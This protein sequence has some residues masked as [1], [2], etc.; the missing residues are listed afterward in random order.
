KR[1]EM[2]NA[3]DYFTNLRGNQKTISRYGVFGY[4]IGGPV[5]IPKVWNVAKNKLFFFWSQEYTRT[6]PASTTQEAKVP[7]AAQLQ[8]NFYDRCLVGTGVNG[9][10]C[11]PGYTDNNGNDRSTFLLNPAAGKT[12]LTGGNLNI[13]IGTPVYN[14]ASA[15]IGQAM[16]KYL[17]SPNLCTAAAGIYNGNAISPGNC[18]SGFSN[19]AIT[20]PTWNYG[21]NYIWSATE[22]HPRRNDTVRF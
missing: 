11:T 22:V 6:K 2:F 20:D 19:H 13:L 18:P 15:A 1:H 5:Y 7:T 10:P 8:G 12:Q 4:T 14:A 9:V 17:P 16:L 3:K 21:F